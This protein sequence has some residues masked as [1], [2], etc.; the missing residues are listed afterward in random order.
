WSG[1]RRPSPSPC[2]TPPADGGGRSWRN[3]CVLVH[4]SHENLAWRV[5]GEQAWTLKRGLSRLSILSTFTAMEVT[6]DGGGTKASAVASSEKSARTPPET[7][8]KK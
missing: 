6:E 2:E 8:T 1:R 3:G 7:G 4:P 5:A